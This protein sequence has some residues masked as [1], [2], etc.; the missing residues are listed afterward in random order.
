MLYKFK[1]KCWIIFLYVFTVYQKLYNIPSNFTISFH[2]YDFLVF[3]KNIV[4]YP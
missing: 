4:G 3:P 2:S 1:M